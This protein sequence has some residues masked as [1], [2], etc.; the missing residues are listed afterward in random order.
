MH[1]VPFPVY[2]RWQVQLKDPTVSVQLALASQLCWPVVHS[3]ISKRKK[4]TNDYG[5]SEVSIAYVTLLLRLNRNQQ[6]FVSLAT[7]RYILNISSD[8]VGG[9]SFK[10]RTY[11]QAYTPTVQEWGMGGG[12][13]VV[14][15]PALDFC[16]VT[17]FG[18]YFNCN[19]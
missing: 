13:W 2:P 10:P 4:K 19:R 1:D 11:T 5:V 15:T 12:G 16:S 3:L 7:S 17:I 6:F 18:K 14:A 9:Q 8:V